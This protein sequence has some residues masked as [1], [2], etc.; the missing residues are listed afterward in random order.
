VEDSGP[1]R[2]TLFD[3]AGRVLHEA[4]T[5]GTEHVL[6]PEVALA[7]GRRYTW[8]VST[9]KANGVEHAN[10]GD[11]AI[12]TPRMRSEAASRRPADDAPFSQRLAFAVWLDTHELGDA[13]R[14]LWRRL[15]DERPGD[16]QLERMA[17]Q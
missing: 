4:T 1:Y 14:G 8:E 11:F 5:T 6:P 16:E 10:F 7:Q 17:E 9:R 15:A 2:V 3:D 12:A 13:A